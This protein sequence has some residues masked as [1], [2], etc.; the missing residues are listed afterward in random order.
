MVVTHKRFLASGEAYPAC[1]AGIMLDGE[2]VA[3]ADGWAAV[4]CERCL[5][6]RPSDT[7]TT[8][9]KSL[10]W[11]VINLVGSALF[12]AM[13]IAEAWDLGPFVAATGLA[14]VVLAL[15]SVG[16]FVD[17]WRSFSDWW[18]E[19]EPAATG[20]YMECS[21]PADSILCDKCEEILQTPTDPRWAHLLNR[22]DV[23]VLD[24]QTTG[25]DADAEV[26]DVAAIDTHGRVL[27]YDL[28]REGATSYRDIHGPLMRVLGHASTICVYNA[29][30]DM[31]MI[32]Q[33]A[34]RYG[35][36]ATVG[37]DVVCIMQEYAD[38]YPADGRWS[39]LDSV[40][41]AE[42]VSIGGARHRPLTDARLTLGLMRAVV[43]RESAQARRDKVEQ[44]REGMLTEDDVP[45]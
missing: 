28:R 20:S 33:S 10:C 39:N 29:G 9:I 27:L 30:F 17:G 19:V 25:L 2:A 31:Q 35:L 41:A 8:F 6:L 14:A 37:A 13:S 16:M 22:H 18:G 4:T 36:D 32:E 34:A 43:Q 21:N 44:K 11:S 38:L 42:G 5:C 12:V 1:G 40:A 3:L 23:L 7:V 45:C 15:C 26:T 24:A